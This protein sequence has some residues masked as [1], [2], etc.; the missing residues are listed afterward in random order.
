MVQEQT[1]KRSNNTVA[2]LLS[3]AV[4]F[5]FGFTTELNDVLIPHLKAIFE[6]NYTRAMLIQFCFFAAYFIMALPAGRIVSC[7][8]YKDGIV[9]GLLISGGGA[10]LVLPAATYSSY[11]LFLCALFILAS[12]IVLLQC[13]ANPYVSLL[14]DPSRAASRLNL[15]GAVNSAG[16]AIGPSIGGALIF[17]T[18]SHHI[19]ELQM[20]PAAEQV[21]SVQPLY[22]GLALVF[23]ALAFITRFLGLPLHNETKEEK[24]SGTFYNALKQR[25]LRLG[26]CAIFLYVGAEVTIGSFI[27]NYA[28]R[29]DIGASTKHGVS[30][31]ISIY[32]L[33]AMVGRFLGAALL[34]KINPRKVLVVYALLN[35]LLLFLSAVGSG[36]FALW[37]LIAVGFFNSIMFP[38]IF[39][40]AIDKLGPLTQKAS[41]LLIMAI[42]GGSIIPV[43]QGHL[44][45]IFVE[46]FGN[47][48]LALQYAFI[49]PALCY[50]Y[51]AWYGSIIIASR[52]EGSKTLLLL[53]QT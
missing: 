52:D 16:H 53:E 22:L 48:S 5:I 8:G 3:T 44:V 20:L 32:W 51:V 45:D 1:V 12:G 10:F 27:A 13:A 40:L 37:T 11:A 23:I 6:L 49:L 35:V 4:F 42:C 41:S 39:T 47:E 34:C 43:L 38:T 25:H 18:T 29:P 19:Q 9:Y 14:G 24:Q 50:A 17:S 30:F 2:L 33:G 26:V 7:C 15:A 46:S 36:Q 28:M 21:H 31:Y